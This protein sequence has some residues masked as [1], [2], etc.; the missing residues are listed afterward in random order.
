MTS[1]SPNPSNNSRTWRTPAAITA[2]V[3]AFVAVAGL[4][5]DREKTKAEEHDRY[6]NQLHKDEDIRNFNLGIDAAI[7]DIVQEIDQIDR[8]IERAVGDRNVASW[9]AKSKNVDAFD[10]TKKEEERDAAVEES[11]EALRI[12]QNSQTII[13][14]LVKKKEK[15]KANRIDLVKSKK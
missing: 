5:Y 7:Y 8:D 2:I 6:I 4:Y 12:M 3:G 11:K 13:D 15:L 14:E 1:G 9:T 10:N